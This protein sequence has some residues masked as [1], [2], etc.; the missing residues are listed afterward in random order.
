MIRTHD[1]LL[2]K[3]TRYRCVIFRK[4][5]ESRIRTYDE[6]TQQIYSLPLLTAQPFLRD[7]KS[8]HKRLSRLYFFFLNF[9]RRIFRFL[10][11]L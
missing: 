9:L 8:K 3:Q 11:P 1:F 2:P 4:T 10:Q 5:E 6:K 7:I